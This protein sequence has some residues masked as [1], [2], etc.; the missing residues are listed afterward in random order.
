MQRKGIL[1]LS[2]L[3]LVASFLA[4]LR[5]RTWKANDRW[6]VP[7]STGLSGSV[8]FLVWA[9]NDCLIAGLQ[10]QTV[11]CY[12]L[13]C[14]QPVWSRDLDGAI[15]AVAASP[16]LVFVCSNRIKSPRSD[17]S[18]LETSDGSARRLVTSEE[19]GKLCGYSFF[20][21]RAIAW[22]PDPGVLAVANFSDG[23]PDNICFVDD[24][25]T[26]IISKATAPGFTTG[27]SGSP[28]TLTI[29]EM[30]NQAHV[31]D[32]HS[33]RHLQHWGKGNSASPVDGAA[34]SN[35]HGHAD[36]TLALVHDNGGWSD[37]TVEIT[38]PTKSVSFSSEN[39]HAVTAVDWNHRVIAIS[40]TSKNL[41]LKTLEGKAVGTIPNA[42]SDRIL[43][44]S[45]S[46]NGQ[47][48][49]V[50]SQTGE[51]RVFKRPG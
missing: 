7:A 24:D 11:N 37:G 5:A 16:D 30:S 4:L 27:V 29:C 36:G 43:K 9:D 18:I 45:F 41:V 12:R 44:V 10:G 14:A 50:M 25:L 48:V 15:E 42:C 2:T 35:A 51:V 20:L 39:A 40:G 23:D 34:L 13:G 8:V 22:L 33:G 49:A 46:P 17:L 1:L 28:G 38:S 26:K 47:H 21:P 31:I 3:L 32:A 19:L 6:T